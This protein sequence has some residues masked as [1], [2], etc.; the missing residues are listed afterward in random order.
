[1]KRDGT[2]CLHTYQS[3]FFN[4]HSAVYQLLEIYH[5]QKYVNILTNYC[6]LF[7]SVVTFQKLLTRGWHE[8]LIKKIKSCGISECL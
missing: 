5:K 4:G 2:C 8:G 6:Q 3:R 7:Q 1:M